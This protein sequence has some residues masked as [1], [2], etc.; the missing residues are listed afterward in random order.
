MNSIIRKLGL[1]TA[2]VSLG[3]SGGVHAQGPV[4]PAVL[5][6]TMTIIV[7]FNPGAS[8]D[9]FAR[10]LAQKLGAKIG[11]NVMVDNKPGAGG[12]IGSGYVARA[13][14]DGSVLL[15]TSSTFTT[16]AAVQKKLPYD[17]ARSFAPVAMLAT[18][19][20][21]LTVGAQTPYKNV[22]E[23]LADARANKGRISYGSAGVGSINHLSSELLDSMAHTDMVHVSYKGTATAITDMI[24][25]QIHSMI[26]SP[27]SIAGQIKSGKVRAL[28]VT[29]PKPSRLVPGVPAL[30]DSVPGYDV[31]I[32]W[33]VFAP[34]GTSA[35][36]VDKLNGEIRAIVDSP[37]MRERFAHEGAEPSTNLSAE[38]FAKYVGGELDKWR[39]LAQEKNIAA[40]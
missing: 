37:E 10:V 30:A 38:Q 8:N 34:A 17:P 31:Q 25:G 5:P 13:P 11:A 1:L 9:T 29:S 6:K 20:M 35:A 23:L 21:I 16:S 7:P 19:P 14:K 26:A 4:A 39:K 27:S 33:G 22:A 24:S 2:G 40:E 36:V 12:V 15:L 18:A 3:F 28:A 32:W